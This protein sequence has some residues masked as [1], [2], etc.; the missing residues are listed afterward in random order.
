MKKHIGAKTVVNPHP[1]FVVGSY[2]AEGKPNIMVVSW[3]GIC[4][5]D[6]PSIAIA[7]REATLTYHNIMATKAFTV[8][9]PSTEHLKEVDFAGL[10][11]GKEY[12]KFEVTGLT[13]VK[14]EVVNAPYVKEFPYALECKVSKT[15]EIGLHTQFIGQIM[16][17]IADEEVLNEKGWPDIEKVKP[18]LYGGFGSRAYYSIGAKLE[19]AFSVGKKF[20][21]NQE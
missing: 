5:S 14:S 18:F 10:Y 3:G 1:T 21:E 12:D 6:P 19:K 11:S 4:C 13:A 8:C 9:I 7:L 15:V 2:N 20:V 17:I 16:D